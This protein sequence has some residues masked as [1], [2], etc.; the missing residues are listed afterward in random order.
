MDLTFPIE[1]NVTGTPVSLQAKRARSKEAWKEKV[2]AASREVLPDGHFATERPVAVT[3]YDF[4]AVPRTGDIDNILKPTLDALIRHV[5]LNDGQVER[6]V[7]QKF[8]PDDVFPFTAPSPVL[9]EALQSVRPV[10][11]IRLSDDPFEDL[12]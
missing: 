7:A 9:A 1:F 12:T 8:K 2:R 10:V 11:Y 3:L 6:I 4:T 5:Y